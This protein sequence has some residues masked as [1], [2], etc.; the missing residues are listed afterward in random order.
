VVNIG[1]R[2]PEATDQGGTGQGD[3]IIGGAQVRGSL[4]IGRLR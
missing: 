2:S 3:L 4:D 1:Q